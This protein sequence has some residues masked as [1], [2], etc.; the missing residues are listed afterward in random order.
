MKKKG[1]LNRILSKT[2][3]AELDDPIILRNFGESVARLR[4][5]SKLTQSD[6]A[7]LLGISKQTYIRIENGSTDK[8]NM[9][10]AI[11]IATIFHVPVKE[12][13]GYDMDDMNLYNN[14][15]QATGRTRRLIASILRIDA[16]G[17]K[18]MQSHIE[19]N[20]YMIVCLSCANDLRDGVAADRFYHKMVNISEYRTQSW[21]RDADAIIEVN[22]NAYVPLYHNED[23]LVISCR[24]PQD[25]DIGI[26]I[27]DGKFYLR[28]YVSAD[29]YA[30]LELLTHDDSS[31]PFFALGK[32]DRVELEHWTKFGVVLE[33]I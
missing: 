19:E 15:I 24:T 3:I 21:Y 29:N 12:L 26:F 32:K 8:I 27:R 31:N 33:V 22:S 4:T 13:C 2:H 14:I 25:G 18:R 7:Y 5:S 9:I 20:E 28:K 10:C 1:E 23:K 17:Q 11:K 16:E 30:F 6:M